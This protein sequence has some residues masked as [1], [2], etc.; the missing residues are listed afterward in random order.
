MRVNEIIKTIKYKPIEVNDFGK[1]K[2]L[3]SFLSQLKVD[4]K[5]VFKNLPFIALTVICIVIVFTEIYNRIYHSGEYNDSIF[6]TTNV[7]IELISTPFPF[8]ATLLIVFYSGE[9]IWK[10]RDINFNQIIDATP[11]S[12]FVFFLSKTTALIL[13][14]LF[15]ITIS[16]VVAIIFQVANS[17]Y[18]LQISQYLSMYYFLGVGVLFNILLAIFIQSISSNKYFGMVVTGLIIIAFQTSVADFLGIQQSLF[19]IGKLPYVEYTNM[20][21]FRDYTA[22]FN[23]YAF[24][25]LLLGV[26]MSFLSYKIWHRGSIFNFKSKI[27]L[28]KNGWNK[29]PLVAFLLT[30]L[31]FIT[32][33]GYIFYKTNVETSYTTNK[34]IFDKREAY[35]RKYKKFQNL[36]SLTLVNV[37]TNVEIFPSDYSYKL[38]ANNTLK[39]LNND[40]V[41]R[42]LVRE[43][44]PLKSLEIEN[45]D[46]IEYDSILGTY[47]FEFKNKIAF[48]QQI[49]FSYE[50][51]K[52]KRGFNIS[53]DVVNN[54][55]YITSNMFEPVIGYQESYEIQDSFERTKRGLP[56]KD[57]LIADN[58]ISSNTTVSKV[59]FETI[60]STQ[61]NQIAI[62]PG[63]LL[64]EWE[65]S[66]RKYFHYKSSNKIIPNIG[67]FSAKY[68]INVEQYKGVNIELYY[69][70]NHDYNVKEINSFTKKSLDYFNSNFGKYPYSHLRIVEIPSH[71]N[72][73]GYAHAGTISMNESELYLINSSE[74]NFNLVAKRTIHEISHQW[75]GHLLTPKNVAGSS[76]LVEGLAK[77]AEAVVM[78]KELGKSAVWQLSSTANKEYFDGRAYSTDNEPPLNATTNQR[79]LAYGKSYTIM[80]ALKDLIGKEKVNHIIKTF[81][82]EHKGDSNISATLSNFINEVYRNTPIEYHHLINDWFNKVI[83]YQLKIDEVIVNELANNKFQI[84]IKIDAKRFEKQENNIVALNSI[85]EPIQVGLF[86]KHPSIIQNKDDILSLKHYKIDDS[87]SL[88]SVITNKVPKYVI[89]DPFITRLD[90]NQTDNMFKL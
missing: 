25:W 53:R 85:N 29:I 22:R 6:P 36:K 4:L 34:E 84:D 64:K 69:D 28:I 90:I 45:A 67:Y 57:E 47:L 39:N 42:I 86:Q 68:S 31:L 54:G 23:S 59:N 44:I 11:A 63:E 43:Q 77:Y 26:I 13:L 71:W 27:G 2:F 3:L 48:G 15:L 58:H 12:N 76:I 24:Y 5:Y 17:Y 56:I 72:F 65:G 14:P 52:E 38:K 88:I 70:D 20:T 32:T 75:F 18:T 78:E 74:D 60:V 89:I 7:L 33:S 10:E 35:E 79:Y 50:L 49:N 83:T 46:L 55:S 61:S 30:V 40:S 9:L 19:R 51:V 21:G 80:L 62:A 8:L 82:N 41:K 16:I 1:N 73:A 81:I 87:K 37:K 66:D